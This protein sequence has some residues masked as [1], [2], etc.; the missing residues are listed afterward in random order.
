MENYKTD[1]NQ[2]TGTIFFIIL[3]LLFVFIFF[4][5]SESQ[6]SSQS[7]YSLQNEI[8]FGNISI[9]DNAALVRTINLPDPCKNQVNVPHNTNLNLFTLS[10][11]IS[12][13]NHRT[14]NNLIINQKTRLLIEPLF[15]WRVYY[16]LPLSGKADPAVLG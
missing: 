2:D 6:A 7:G 11:I 1:T 8:A 15:L 16:L 13:Y 14:E 12:N 9:L 5:K 4:C 3:F 10:Y